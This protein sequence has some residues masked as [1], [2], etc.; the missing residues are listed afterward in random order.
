MQCRGGLVHNVPDLSKDVAEKGSTRGIF[1][2]SE[3]EENWRESQESGEKYDK[4]KGE[5]SAHR[6]GGI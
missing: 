1:G 2:V 5:R 3:H 4:T 6:R